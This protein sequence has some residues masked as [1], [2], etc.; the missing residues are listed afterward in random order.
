MCRQPRMRWSGDA[1]R[2]LYGEEVGEAGYRQRPAAAM[3]QED[4]I[5]FPF[6]GDADL[7]GAVSGDRNPMSDRHGKPSIHVISDNL[8]QL[9]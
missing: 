5:T 4:G 9:V 6:F 2:S 8:Y 3:E 7:D 1:R